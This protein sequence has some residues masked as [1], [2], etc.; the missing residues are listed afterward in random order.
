MKQKIMSVLLQTGNNLTSDE[1]MWAAS[2]LPD[3]EQKGSYDPQNDQYDHS[4][5]NVFKALCITK[6]QAQEVAEVLGIATTKLIIKSRSE[7]YKMSNA[8]QEVIEKGNKI[9]AFQKLLVA[10]MIQE[11]LQQMAEIKGFM[12]DDDD[13]E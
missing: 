9:P 11:A 6:K 12:N 5:E 8:V 1:I 3:N 13:D 10:K 4:E 7:K 2:H